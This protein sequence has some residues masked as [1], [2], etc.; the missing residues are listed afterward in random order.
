M[1]SKKEVKYRLPEK[2]ARKKKTNHL[3]TYCGVNLGNGRPNATTGKKGV[4]IKLSTMEESQ[5]GP[6]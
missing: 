6:C 4:I 5:M 1:R 2:G 3:Y